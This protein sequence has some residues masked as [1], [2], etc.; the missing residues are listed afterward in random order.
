MSHRTKLTVYGAGAFGTAL[1]IA[2][3][4]RFERVCLVARSEAAAAR[5]SADRANETYLP[6]A[7][8]PPNVSVT[9][10]FEPADAVLWAVPAQAMGQTLAECADQL[11]PSSPVLICAKGLDL[12][13]GRR[14]SKVAAVAAPGINAGFLSGPAFAADIAAGM[15]TAMTLALRSGALD[16]A[17]T[18][19]TNRLRLYASEDVTGVELGG[20]L[21]N[22]VAIASGVAMG[23]GFGESARAAL[24]TRGF[25]EMCRIAEALGA[26]RETLMGLSGFGDLMLTASSGQSRNVAYG[27]ALGARDEL[28]TRLAE[29]AKTA[30]VAYTLAADLGVDTPVIAQTV[31]LLEGRTRPTEAMDALLSRDVRPE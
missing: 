25:A 2:F 28:P 15:P 19:S 8:L 14:L 6:G 11:S 13:S 29:G 7:R 30:S 22:V 27:L 5:L 26:K 18:M 9:A 23:A 16:M 31:A 21:K 3:S 20:A 17:Q 10:A 24:V 4:E 1:A 12:A